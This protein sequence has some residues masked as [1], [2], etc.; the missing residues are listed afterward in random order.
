M[1]PRA[2]ASRKTER[3]RGFMSASSSAAASSRVCTNLLDPL[4]HPLEYINPLEWLEYWSDRLGGCADAEETR[5]F[6]ALEPFVASSSLEPPLVAANRTLAD[7]QLDVVVMRFATEHAYA[8]AAASAALLALAIALRYRQGSSSAAARSMG[9]IDARSERS[10]GQPPKFRLRWN[11]KSNASQS[12]ASSGDLE[13]QTPRPKLQQPKLPPPPKE[14]VVKQQQRA[15]SPTWRIDNSVR[16][17]VIRTSLRGSLVQSEVV[18][19]ILPNAVA[20]TPRSTHLPV[21]N[22]R[23]SFSEIL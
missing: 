10:D 16:Q 21:K 18:A 8:L 7:D 22:K 23:Q 15:G 4:Y 19:P 11:S 5:H 6:A 9:L 12:T 2:K 3:I 20:A 14:W 17:S 1:K 13:S